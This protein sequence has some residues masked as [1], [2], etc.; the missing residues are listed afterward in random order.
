MSTAA[1]ITLQGMNNYGNR[2]QNYAMQ[3]MLE[4]S[5]CR[6]V[7]IKIGDRNIARSIVQGLRYVSWALNGR[8][9]KRLLRKKRFTAFE[10][11]IRSEHC[12]LKE[13]REGMLNRY[14]YII[15]GSDQIWNTE[16]DTFSKLFLGYYAN[17]DKNIAVS[18]S[19]GTDDIDPEYR[20]L[21]CEGLQRFKAVSVREDAG[22]EIVEKYTDRACSVVPD[23]TLMLDKDQ[24][25]GAER[26]VPV[27]EEYAFT[28][29]LGERPDITTSMPLIH[30]ERGSEY[31]P[32]EFLYLIRNA[33]AVYTDS[34]HA[35]V[36]CIIHSVPFCVYKRKSRYTAMTSRIRTL[37]EA[38]GLPY[39]AEREYCHYS[40]EEL[41]EEVLRNRMDALRKSMEVFL[42]ENLSG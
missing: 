30:G 18:A 8:K 21:F 25:I 37:I 1:I 35:C 34:F 11:E 24:W 29:F 7:T 41:S 12:S 40:K 31:G 19:F 3:E 9:R 15:Y 38:F 20:E 26:P 14:D 10:R 16:F 22:K 28:Y 27:P 32:G 36:F 17:R 13:I 33:R 6:A 5:G 42:T 2:L 23:P 4:Q 39:D